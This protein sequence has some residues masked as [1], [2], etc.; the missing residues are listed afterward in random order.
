MR[1]WRRAWACAIPEG[2]GLD[3][4][5]HAVRRILDQQSNWLLIFDNASGVD[6]VRNYIPIER[7]G[8][9]LVTS[10]NPTGNRLRGLSRSSR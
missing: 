6:D 5:R 1:S 8:H 4:I 10:R 3:D 2:T 9:V 7:K